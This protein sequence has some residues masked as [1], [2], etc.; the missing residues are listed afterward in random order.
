MYNLINNRALSALMISSIA[1][2]TVACAHQETEDKNS[3]SEPSVSTQVAENDSKTSDAPRDKVTSNDTQEKNT[4]SVNN[5]GKTTPT[6]S[7]PSTSLSTDLSSKNFSSGDSRSPYVRYNDSS[8]F[9]AKG[10]NESHP[11]I[12]AT[13]GMNLPLVNTLGT[14]SSSGVENTSFSDAQ[15]TPYTANSD[16]SNHR[17]NEVNA[18][19]SGTFPVVDS[20]VDVEEDTVERVVDTVETLDQ[21]LDDSSSSDNLIEIPKVDS[22]TDVTDIY[23]QWTAQKNDAASRLADADKAVSDA[24]GILRETTAEYDRLVVRVNEA[25]EAFNK[26]NDEYEKAVESQRIAQQEGESHLKD[27]LDVAKQNLAQA[28]VD[29]ANAKTALVKAQEDMSRVEAEKSKAVAKLEAIDAGIS[30]LDKRIE[31]NESEK[32]KLEAQKTPS[33][34]DDFS[35]EEYQI[36]VAQAVIEMVN[37][38]RVENGVAPLRTHDTFN[39]SARAWSEQMASDGKSVPASEFGDAFRHSPKTWGASGENIAGMYVGY[40][41]NLDKRDWAYV[42]KELFELWRNSPSHNEAMLGVQAQGVGVGVVVDDYGRVWATAQFFKEDTQFTS[43]ARVNMDKGTQQA[44]NSGKDFYMAQ[45][46]M[47]VLGVDWFVP[48]DTNGAHPDYQYIKNGRGSQEDKVRGL[49]HGVDDSVKLVTD[50]AD[51]SQR[52]QIYS[53]IAQLNEA[54]AGFWSQKEDAVAK[55]QQVESEVDGFG[56]AHELATKRADEAEADVAKASERVAIAEAEVKNA[57]DAVNSGV[58]HT[59]SSDVIVARD[60]AEKELTS[61]QGQLEQSKSEVADAQNVL[62]D[63]IVARSNAQVEYDGI[64]AAEPSVGSVGG[65]GSVV[66]LSSPVEASDPAENVSDVVESSASVEKTNGQFVNELSFDDED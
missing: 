53:R 51:A 20:H 59:V 64:V 63:A 43:G 1:L 9:S 49:S 3:L 2:T 18:G 39:Y 8:N 12:R 11:S 47:D 45:G 65:E 46:A 66:A 36:L 48:R 14:P 56:R 13:H 27:A 41:E 40:P 37:T 61:V 62:T 7:R 60:V 54:N 4:R 35:Q 42:S 32:V 16:K 24:T 57:Q 5:L 50:G 33:V 30:S 52:A 10:F 19:F 21:H 15:A 17:Y 58:D 23:N 29:E 26:A 55:R 44:L 31:A 28:K 6:L 22:E 38:Y 25:N 34:R